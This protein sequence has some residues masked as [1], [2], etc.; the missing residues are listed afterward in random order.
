MNGAT[1]PAVM[2]SPFRIA[3][4]VFDGRL[5]VRYVGPGA[6]SVTETGSATI[7][8]FDVPGFTADSL[9][10]DV[11]DG[12]LIVAGRREEAEGDR[13]VYSE[14]RMTSFRRILT[15]DRRLDPSAIT[16]DLANGVL[17]VTVAR[18][19][20]SERRRIDVRTAS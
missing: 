14:R 12:R 3:D 18:R 8:E 7:F 11:E 20:E 6:V 17:K 5:D 10:I 19:P 1:L 13:K 2:S 15:L 16:A 4:R 9:S